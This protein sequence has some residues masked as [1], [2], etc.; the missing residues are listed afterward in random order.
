MTDARLRLLIGAL[1]MLLGGALVGID[2]ADGNP[3]RG[4][5]AAVAA[6]FTTAAVA[7]ARP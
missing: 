7:L 5:T 4:E 1:T 3:L 6:A 2:L